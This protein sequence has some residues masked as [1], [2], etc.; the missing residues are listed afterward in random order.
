MSEKRINVAVCAAGIREE[1]VYENTVDI[2]TELNRHGM[3]AQVFASL[4][5]LYYNDNNA[6]GC[7]A[8]FDFPADDRIS[9]VIIMS[10]TF[11]NGDAVQR[12]ISE[13][14]R[15]NMPV[16]SVDKRMDGCCNVLYDYADAFEKIVRHLT[17]DHKCRSINMIAGTK[18]N[19]FSDE[20]IKVYKRVLAES[21]I[22]FDE[23]RL[24]YGDFWDAPAREAVNKFLDS[25]M[26]LPDAIVCANDSMAIAVCGVLADRGY[27]V[28]QDIIVTGFDGIEQER[29]HTPRLTTAYRNSKEAAKQA[30]NA[31]EEYLKT[32]IISTED[33]P[34]KYSVVYSQSC[35][36]R[37][38]EYTNVNSLVMLLYRRMK[39]S[40][41]FTN[42]MYTMSSEMIDCSSIDEA[43][44]KTE[45]HL[46]TLC[47][48]SMM[49]CLRSSVMN[50]APDTRFD[51]PF[52]RGEP[53]LLAMIRGADFRLPMERFALGE[54][55]E[56]A[57]GYQYERS[58]AIMYLSVNSQENIYGFMAIGFDPEWFK[59][60]YLHSFMVEFGKTIDMISSRAMLIS[61]NSRLSEINRKLENMYI[62]DS[63][64]GL[65]NRPGFYM[66]LTELYRQRAGRDGYILVA[67]IDMDGLKYIN[68]TF[69]HSEGDVSIRA[70]A[71]AIKRSTGESGICARFGG[72][73]FMAVI[74]ADA[75]GEESITGFEARLRENLDRENSELR[76]SYKVAAS[77]GIEFAKISET[78][79]IE[80]IMKL[81]DD[82]MYVCKA[83]NKKRN[84][85]RK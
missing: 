21:G 16:I 55:P 37:P 8:I 7:T 2:C 23:K 43:I 9:A 45:S 40:E 52:R 59:R 47:S 73:E 60:E 54:T 27:R 79:D 18:G 15:R 34:V 20:R 4:S 17:V 81:A 35:G 49:L 32:G 41:E 56:F 69:G 48:D 74:A 30:V 57:S 26:P 28:P 22:P 66:R 19:P 83:R 31:V 61:A 76:R 5:D 38:I 50:S 72:D 24:A 33:R 78:L 39:S 85:N 6:R 29:L 67:S 70:T 25:G 11:K 63:L 51:V 77:C 1:S 14:L 58:G 44:R 62:H 3:K 36:C 65:L 84:A 80:H 53:M 42:E 46:G 68:D 64:T 13:A 12:I 10:E 75:P 71:E 82:K